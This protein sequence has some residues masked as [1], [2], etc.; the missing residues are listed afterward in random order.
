MSNTKFYSVEEFKLQVQLPVAEKAQVVKSP[1]TGK[2]F[3]AIGSK[4]FKCQAT[5]DGSKEMRMLVEDDN[6]NEACLVNVK[7]SADN[8]LFTL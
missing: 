7:Q 8:V 3:L 2:L 4:N 5:I 6:F 1:S